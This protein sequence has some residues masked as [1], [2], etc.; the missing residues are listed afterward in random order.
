MAK[1]QRRKRK[2]GS[3]SIGGE[4]HKLLVLKVIERNT[5]GTPKL[6]EVL[7]DDESTNVEEG[8]EFWTCYVPKAF[9]DI[10]PKHLKN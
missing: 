6:V 4:I 2:P 10:N 7:K 1:P 8:T 3:T 5:D 9:V